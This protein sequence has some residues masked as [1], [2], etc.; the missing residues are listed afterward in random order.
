VHARIVVAGGIRNGFLKGFMMKSMIDR[1]S[2]V[3]GAAGATAL[4]M[5]PRRA[6]ALPSVSEVAQDIPALANPA[7]DVTI[8]EI[9]DYQC[10]Y[11]KL[12]YLEIMKLV[13]EDPGI[14]LVIKDWPVFGPASEF[15]ARALLASADD[16][17]HGVAVDRLMRNDRKLTKRRAEE[18]LQEAGIDPATLADRMATRRQEIDLILARNAAHAVEFKL[19]GTPALLVG[20]VLYRHGL[21]LEDLRKAAADARSV[22][23]AS[24]S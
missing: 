22:P 10:P 19:Q 11:C 1:R 3:A 15:A 21:P 8:V 23:V 12:C 2:F 14:R 24:G 5:L 17:A 20:S 18:I 6:F 7:G 13:A 4:A 16:P 9:V